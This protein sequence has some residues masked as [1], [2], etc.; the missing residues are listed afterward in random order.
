[1]LAR[2]APVGFALEVAEQLER[3]LQGHSPLQQQIL[4]CVAHGQTNRAIA[5]EVNLHERTV[6]QLFEQIARQERLRANAAP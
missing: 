3:L 1:L 5:T 4:R 6:R 2:E